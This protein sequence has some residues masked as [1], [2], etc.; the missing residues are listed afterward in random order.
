MDDEL[1]DEALEKAKEIEKEE[2]P[3]PDKEALEKDD[4]KFKKE[5]EE[6]HELMNEIDDDK[7]EE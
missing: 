4:K 3:F 6:A 1:K 5:S 2:E 7:E